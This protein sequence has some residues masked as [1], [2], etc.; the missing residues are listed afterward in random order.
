MIMIPPEINKDNIGEKKV[1]IKLRDD[2]NPETKDWVVYH[3]LNYPV[4]IKKK[5]KKSFTYFGEADFVILVPGK[6]IINL[7]V[8]GWKRFSCNDG[9]W[10][11]IK[12]DGTEVIDKKQ[13]PLKQAKD[14]MYT[15][16]KYIKKKLNKSFP[17]T[18]LVIFTQCNFDNVKDNIEYSAN[19]IIDADTFDKDFHNRVFN[20]TKNLKEGGGSFNLSSQDLRTLKSKIMRPNFEIFVKTPTILKESMNELHEF[21]NEQIEILDHIDYNSKLL[22]TGTQG[23]G[24]TAIAEEVIKREIQK[25]NIKKI[26]FLNSNRLAKEETTHKLKNIENSKKLTCN[27]FNK[28]LRDLF[29]EINPSQ[30]LNVNSLSFIEQH[31]LM[32]NECIKFLKDKVALEQWKKA[33]LVDFS[34]KYKFD[35]I[36]FDEMQN[37]YFYDKFYEL[38]D[39]LLNGGLINGK[40]CF[41]GDFYLQNLVSDSTTISKEKH[42]RNNLLD[43]REIN[44]F[45]NVRNAK[46]I[47]RQAP[48]LSGLFKEKFPYVLAKSEHG[49]VISFFS[50]SRSEKIEKLESILKKLKSDEVEGND[51]VLISNYRLNNHRNFISEAKISNYYNHIIDLTDQNIRNL[52]KNIKKEKNSSSIYFSTTSAFQGMESKIVIYIDPLETTDNIMFSDTN[53]L[54]PE[55]LAFNAMGRANTLLYL[56]WNS[57]FEKYYNERIKI[58]G[59][60][61]VN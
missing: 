20:I 7:E 23:T 52:N 17:Q 9:V 3:S 25:R 49:N 47:S 53:V 19:N 60:L 16:N 15:I 10:R 18:W 33:T 55:M 11:I 48:I 8:K 36:V 58:I 5:N 2:P 28:F 14:S 51:I 35:L 26:L 37:C 13:G 44:L 21:T 34:E 43:T 32:I 46:S 27:T 54:R 59:N 22:V 24:K 31:N 42:P 40:Y 61:S 6:G 12:Q 45:K 38:I 39:L 50:K 56:L 4:S 30:A 1:F 57:S 29:M 41:L